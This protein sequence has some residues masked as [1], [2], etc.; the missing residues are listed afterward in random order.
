[1]PSIKKKLSGGGAQTNGLIAPG[2]LLTLSILSTNSVPDPD[3]PAP[4]VEK[5]DMR[6]VFIVPGPVLRMLPATFQLTA[7]S[8]AACVGPGETV[9]KVT[10]A[11]SKVKSPWKP[12]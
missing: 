9:R 6:S 3:R 5:A 12:M 11:E 4:S 8:P 1:M 2:V 10:T 7:V